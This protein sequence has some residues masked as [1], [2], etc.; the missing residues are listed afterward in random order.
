M[1][2]GDS[3]KRKGR[4]PAARRRT[5]ASTKASVAAEDAQSATEAVTSSIQEMMAATQQQI[6]K[7]LRI[8]GRELKRVRSH[9]TETVRGMQEAHTN[10]LMQAMEQ[11]QAP[12]PE[13]QEPEVSPPGSDLRDHQYSTAASDAVVTGTLWTDPG[14]VPTAPLVE[15]P[16]ELA[17]LAE[18]AGREAIE[19]TTQ[20]IESTRLASLGFDPASAEAAAEAP[21]VDPGEEGGAGV[22]PEF[23]GSSDYPLDEGSV[24][25]TDSV[26]EQA[27]HPTDTAS[28]DAAPPDSSLG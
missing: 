5:A 27:V 10:A 6:Q 9:V 25:L 19:A 8:F 7:D 16:A 23:G 20:A 15:P 17:S 18:A 26:V 3:S 14:E 11:N 24:A 12:A 13:V 21:P 2:T 4:K 22:S 28:N 1:A